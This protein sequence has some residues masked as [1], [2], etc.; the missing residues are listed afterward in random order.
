MAL[1][2]ESSSPKR[3]PKKLDPETQAFSD[4]AM[5]AMLKSLNKP[6]DH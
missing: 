2:D 5:A 6:G 3:P 4:M 1:L